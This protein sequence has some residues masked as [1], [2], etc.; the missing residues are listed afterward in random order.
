MA[1]GVAWKSKSVD[2]GFD[3]REYIHGTWDMD[4][5]WVLFILGAQIHTCSRKDGLERGGE[6]IFGKV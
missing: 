3:G 5:A 6:N 2:W 4:M 1:F